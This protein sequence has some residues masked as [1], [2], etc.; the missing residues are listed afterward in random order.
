MLN[1]S[2]TLDA[3][4]SGPVTAEPAVAATAVTRRYGEGEAAVH[5]LRG[6]SI[7]VPAS[8]F[9]AIMGPSG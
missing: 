6:V 4:M 5:A 9:T 1:A 8:Q 2:P 7:G 3:V